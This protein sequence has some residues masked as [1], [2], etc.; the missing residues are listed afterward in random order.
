MCKLVLIA[1]ASLALVTTAAPTFAATTAID[2]DRPAAV[3]SRGV[4]LAHSSRY[5]NG[6][7]YM[8]DRSPYRRYSNDP[9]FGYYPTLRYYQRSGRCV[10]DLGYGRFEF[11][12][13]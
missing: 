9:S 4:Q 7:V 11:C 8:R 3:E 2:S 1:A 12:G 10:T 13:W 5:H 6:R